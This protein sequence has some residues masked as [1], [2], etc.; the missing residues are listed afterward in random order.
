MMSEKA[1]KHFER[2][3]Y[4]LA[5][6]ADMEQLM[7]NERGWSCVARRRESTAC[8]CSPMLCGNW[9]RCAVECRRRMVEMLDRGE[10]MG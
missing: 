7:P 8:D 6:A 5:L 9:L 1:K 2:Y 3:S 4:N 10:E